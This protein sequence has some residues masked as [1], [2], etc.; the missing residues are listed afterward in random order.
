VVPDQAAALTSDQQAAF[1]TGTLFYNAHTQANPAGE[2]RGQLDATGTLK[3]ASLDGAQETPA[4]TSDAVGAGVLSVDETT[5]KVRGF[6]ITR[7][8]VDVTMAHVHMAARG[9][10]GAVIVPMVGGPDMWVVPDDAAPLS[11]A[12]ITAFQAG[13]LYFNAHT[14]AHPSGEIRG[15]IDKVGTP[16]LASLDG[17]QEVPAVTTDAF[18]AG[19][20]AVDDATGQ[21][22][23]FLLVSGQDSTVAHV[24]QAARGTPGGVILPL[25][26][27]G[28]LWVVPDSATAFTAELR[29][30]FTNGEL[31]YNAHTAANPSGAIRGQLDV[32][33]TARLTALDGAQ[34]TPP[35]TT[36]AFG[37]G[38]LS[39][40][41]GTGRARGF[42]TTVGLTDPTVAHVHQQARG[43][44]G[45]VIL[46]LAP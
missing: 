43:T 15:Q 27:A 29:T 12:Q 32:P 20:L 36:D 25:A 26:S 6:F 28:D 24:H 31:Y 18:G 21:V 46:P 1:G 40:E 11:A 8:L 9:T 4:V 13:E 42:I 38:I 41:D 39:V 5:G 19:L 2:I 17:A 14:S 3:F 16:R 45:P 34:E 10:P 23:G 30:A 22:S 44:P 7:G 33:G 37:A 35:V